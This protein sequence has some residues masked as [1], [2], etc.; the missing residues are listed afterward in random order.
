M[1]SDFKHGKRAIEHLRSVFLDLR[2]QQWEQNDL[3]NISVVGQ[4][5]HQTIDANAS[6]PAGGMPTRK[7]SMKS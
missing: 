3:S 5:H 2:P 6:P 1:A 4:E 7:A